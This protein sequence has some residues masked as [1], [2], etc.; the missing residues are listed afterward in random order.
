MRKGGILG[1][2]TI[3]LT[4]FPPFFPCTPASVLRPLKFLGSLEFLSRV[5]QPLAPPLLNM[6]VLGLADLDSGIWSSSTIR[7]IM[8]AAAAV[9]DGVVGGVLAVPIPDIRCGRDEALASDVSSSAGCNDNS[10]NS[11]NSS[12]NSISGRGIVSSPIF[13]L[14]D[15][16]L[17]AIFLWVRDLGGHSLPSSSS[18]GSAPDNAYVYSSWIAVTTTTHVC[19][20]WRDIAVYYT[21][22][23]W[24]TLRLG[25]FPGQRGFKKEWLAAALARSRSRLLEVHVGEVGGR[26]DMLEMAVGMLE[27][28]HF[29]RIRRLS[30]DASNPRVV[31]RCLTGREARCLEELRV[32]RNGQAKFCDEGMIMTAGRKP[33]LGLNAPK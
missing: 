24:T 21:P 33:L 26:Q 13:H 14:H 16:I 12:G 18:T 29:G 28:E 7:A 4:Y 9:V 10:S 31:F 22:E 5:V 3:A 32:V 11:S 6:L 15:E 17:S 27:S 25:A 8:E 1:R 23:L 30:M 2:D 19:R 20:R